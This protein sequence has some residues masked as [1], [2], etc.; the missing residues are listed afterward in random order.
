MII[1]VLIASL[2]LQMAAVLFALRLIRITGR[3]A[4]WGF[5]AAAIALMAL[6]S[7]ISVGQILDSAATARHDLSVELIALAISAFIAAG[8]ERVAPVFA[9]TR[10]AATGTQD[11]ET[12]FRMVFENS[13]ISIWEED[14]SAVKAYFERLRAQGV[15]DIE[16]HFD[17]HPE[18]VRECADLARII[19]V[20]RAALELHGAES[21]Q[22]LLAGLTNTFTPESFDT[23][24]EELVCLWQGG[25]QLHRDAVVR[26]L[27]GELR[28]VSVYFAVCPGYEATLGKVIVSLIDITERK[29]AELQL[30]QA[31]ELTEGVINAI[32][33]ILFE[34]DAQGRYLNVWTR[35][36]ELLAAS[37]ERLL[38]RTAREVLPPEAAAVAM[39]AIAEADEKGLSLGNVMRLDLPDGTHWFEHSLSKKPSDDP[40]AEP[41][42]LVLS[43]DVTGR[44]RMEEQL[45]TSEQQFRS[46][47]EN[48]PDNI[49]R[50][51]RECRANYLNRT[52]QQTM[53]VDPE[54]V[55][56]RTPVELG[57][58]GRESDAEYEAHIRQVLENGESSDME[59]TIPGPQGG[60]RHHLIRFSA[61]RDPEGNIVGVLA[62]GRDVTGLKLMD[63][64]LRFVAQQ[65]WS[66]GTEGFFDALVRFLGE[67]LHIEYVLI[68]R[69]DDDGKSAETIALY[70]KG[71][72]EPNLRY[73][74]RGTP[75]E[76]VMGRSLCVYPRDV[77]RLFPED[78]LL[79]EMGVECYVGIPLWDSAGR[80]MGLIAVLGC[81]P[82]DDEIMVTQVLQLVATRAAAEL[83]RQQSDRAL[84]AREHEFRTLAESLPDNI[85]RYDR[86]GRA[87][88]VN[89]SL[90]KLLGTTA[91][92]RIGKRVREYHADGSYESYARALDGVLDSGENCEF[93]FMP[94]GLAEPPRIHYIRM[95]AEHDESGAVTG[96]LSV[97]HDITDQKLREQELSRYRDHLEETVQQRT[98]ALRL[99]RDA[100]EAASRAKSVFLANMSHELRT[101]LNAILGFSSLMR[102]D[103]ELGAA[104]RENLEIIKHS[105]EH[106]LR[107]I[108]DVLEIAK[109]E[110][111]KLQLEIAAFDLH[112]LVR[113]VVD[114]MRLRA[115]QKGLYL[116]LDQSSEFPRYIRGDQARL[117]QILVN[118][119]GNAVKF[120]RH[121][122]VIIRLGVKHNARQQ[123]VMEVED[124]GL[125]IGEQD[126]Q[127]LFQP[128]AQ[129]AEGAAQG[130]TG[131]GLSIVHQFVQLMGGSVAVESTPGAGSL[132]R[133]ELPLE[134]VD[135]AESERL[136]GAWRGNVT[137]LTPGQ[138]RYR[139]LIAEDQQDNQR[140]L[141][142][143]MTGLGFEAQAVD[144]GEACVRL[145]EAWHPD[146]IWMDW[147]MPVMDGVEATRRIRRLA[148][149]ERVKIIAVTASAF[150]EQQ[151]QL[152]A[153][154]MDDYVSKPFRLN[155]IYDALA[156]QL[157][158]EYSYRASPA[159]GEPRVLTPQRLRGLARHL[160]D[161]LHGA[162]ES[163]DRER[164]GAV[165]DRIAAL[166][167]ETGRALEY[168][169]DEFDYPAILSALEAA[170]G[171]GA[172][173]A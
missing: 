51:D 108:N 46:L 143:L 30:K 14:F 87:V 162:V 58:G 98:E 49:I 118:L 64:T 161:E 4:A 149:G 104:Q 77:Q 116:K 134:T 11:S 169:A 114:M 137:G 6:R 95:I 54:S 150:K 147:R 24:R 78:T 127:R 59:L 140:L 91:D 62:I 166:D 124:S 96:V 68:D 119:V 151:A 28:N 154:G 145:F 8:L 101:P 60:M 160:R 39:A 7:G 126:R 5:I 123:L 34:V 85:I 80:A 26:T 22:A 170:E 93:E 122:G 67:K 86:Q 113:E 79:A 111:G 102:Q 10:P 110:A 48:S 43:R 142:R 132:F 153:A 88:Y 163:L 73:A 121:G 103:A 136:A 33:D 105:G 57:A 12:R 21:E 171:P 168:L 94:P 156:R 125:G 128:F 89:A 106:L 19:A 130:G 148:G 36:P 72:I 44:T 69:L 107:L 109:I 100:A 138:P 66:A 172:S 129:L 2:I 20:N 32:P 157:G 112:D 152:S 50:Y 74:L 117:R 75:C 17:R 165:I 158:I 27:A 31:L 15:T 159:T 173:P 167:D 23:F 29:Q 61:D 81:Q 164:I 18:A 40:S 35:N 131:L 25:T 146:L 52:M 141:V 13:P 56:G 76:N 120:T 71:A 115:Q 135:A 92:D 144:D 65:G 55:L 53:T 70:A 45:R 37:K 16:A 9:A 38:G 82:L 83:E 1:F 42:F 133:V 99:A 155:E 3:T 90:Q 84:R 63:E 97:S 41:R 139:I 47:A